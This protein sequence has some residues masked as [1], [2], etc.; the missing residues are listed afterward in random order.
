M[1]ARLAAVGPTK[2]SQIALS[3]SRQPDSRSS[4]IGLH[5]QVDATGETKKHLHTRW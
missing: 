1:A 4:A 2:N 3:H 5:G